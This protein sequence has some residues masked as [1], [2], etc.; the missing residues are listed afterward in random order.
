MVKAQTFAQAVINF[1][2]LCDEPYWGSHIINS[3]IEQA[4]NTTLWSFRI[5]LSGYE[6][7][8]ASL[9]VDWAGYL[10]T[11]DAFID[12][13]GDKT[14]VSFMVDEKD[15]DSYEPKQNDNEE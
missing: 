12:I 14:E 2:Y 15:F 9:L 10:H 3:R 4:D 7:F 1:L 13:E 11:E 5:K 8:P 6:P